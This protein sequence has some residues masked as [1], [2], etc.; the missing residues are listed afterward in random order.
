LGASSHFLCLDAPVTNK[1]LATNPITLMQPDGD[2]MVSTHTGD[3]DLPQLPQAARRCHILPAIKHS[4][5]LVVKLCEAGCKV[6]FMK[7]GVGIEIR[8]RGRLVMEC[9]LNK[10]TGLWMV[11]LPR[12]KPV[13]NH[14]QPQM[15]IKQEGANSD[16]QHYIEHQNLDPVISLCSRSNQTIDY[17]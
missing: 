8:Y 5:I 11:P 16:T 6:K 17:E 4:L 12:Q 1:Q 3:L 2:T 7:W 14:L 13:T 15:H 9:L 10:R